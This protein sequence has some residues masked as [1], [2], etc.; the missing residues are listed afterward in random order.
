MVSGAR[1][2]G[3]A[4][5]SAGP[6]GLGYNEVRMSDK[7]TEDANPTASESREG[8]LL[9]AMLAGAGI[10]IV[11]ALL[12]LWPSGDDGGS[13]PESLAGSAQGAAGAAG[14]GNGAGGR[15]GVQARDFDEASRQSPAPRMN[16][17]VRSRRRA[18][19]WRR[20]CHPR[21]TTRRSSPAARTR[22]PWYEER[23]ARAIQMRDSRQKFVERLP[24]IRERIEEGDNPEEGLKAFEGRRRSSRTTSPRPRLASTSSRRSWPASGSRPRR[25]SVL[26]D[27]RMRRSRRLLHQRVV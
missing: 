1:P 22:S 8:G 7:A 18:P 3:A 5:G 4:A 14:G 9:P 23:L 26:L 19:G 21:A 12:V 27:R 15:G 2:A 11:V 17:A 10:L 6:S 25:R 20:A 16:P 13:G 24:K